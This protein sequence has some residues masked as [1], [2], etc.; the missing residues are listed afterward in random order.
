M[1]VTN[2][3][4]ETA[5]RF[6]ATDDFEL[7]ASLFQPKEPRAL[8]LIAPALAV[9]RSLYARFAAHLAE[10]GLLT[11]VPDYRGVGGSRAGPLRGFRA[12]L[13]DWAEL[14]L[15]ACVAELQRRAPGQPLRGVGHSLGGHMLGLQDPTHIRAALL[16]ASGSGYWRHW[17]GAARLGIGAL[18][19]TIPALAPLVGYWPMS[20]LGQGEDVPRGVAEQ[21]AT[22]GRH[23][24]YVLSHVRKT[25][26]TDSFPYAGPLRAYAFT[27]DPYVPE[28][29]ARALLGGYARAEVDLKVLQPRDLGKPRIGHFGVFQPAFKDGLWTEARSWLLERAAD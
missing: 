7:Q 2:G 9:R 28:R 20:K 25:R 27:D 21:W 18:W 17:S 13:V 3:D 16:I 19:L 14:D 26:R 1:N 10:G 5:I 15:A 23:P 6:R 24:D 11:L 8:A 29:S 4:I 22:W 12:D